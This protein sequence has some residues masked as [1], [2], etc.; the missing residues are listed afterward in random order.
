[1]GAHDLPPPAALRLS[2]Y[3]RILIRALAICERTVAR[4][5]PSRRATSSAGKSST[6]RR[7]SA[8]RSRGV[9][10]SSPAASQSRCSPRSSVSFGRVPDVSFG[11]FAQFYKRHPPAATQKLERGVGCDARQ[12]VRGLQFVFELILPL[13]GF[14]ESFLGQVL[15]VMNCSA[16]RPCDKSE[17]KRGA[18]VR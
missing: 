4:E 1:M 14:D 9:S 8:A 18:D 16:D 3:F 2:A 5:Q 11:C 17:G 7:T 12:P 13:Q 6:S 15:R 10:R